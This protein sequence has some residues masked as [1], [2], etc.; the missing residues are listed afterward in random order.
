VERKEEDMERYL[1]EV[2][3]IGK[4]NSIYLDE[5]SIEYGEIPK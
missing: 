3:G 2:K 5:S 4:N 1:S